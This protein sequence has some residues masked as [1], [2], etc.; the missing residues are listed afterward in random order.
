MESRVATLEQTLTELRQDMQELKQQRARTNHVTQETRNTRN[1]SGGIAGQQQD[2]DSGLISL[3]SD[4]EEE[5]ENQLWTPRTNLIQGI[6]ADPEGSTSSTL[7]NLIARD[8]Q[9]LQQQ[10]LNQLQLDRTRRLSRAMRQSASEARTHSRSRSPVVRRNRE[11]S[12]DVDG[13]PPRRQSLQA[14]SSACTQTSSSSNITQEQGTLPVVH[15]RVRAMIRPTSI[16]DDVSS[17]V[18]SEENIAGSSD[19]SDQHHTAESSSSDFNAESPQWSPD[20]SSS[21]S[22]SDDFGEMDGWWRN[23]V[24]RYSSR[25][26]TLSS[27]VSYLRANFH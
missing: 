5:N 20:H 9:E 14:P 11:I 25:S 21:C 19:E 23:L 15:S 8:L 22:S 24:N 16:E 18:D 26:A 27:D 13:T 3:L 2:G 17:Q 10:T 4:D 7:V 12:L 6:I 1:S